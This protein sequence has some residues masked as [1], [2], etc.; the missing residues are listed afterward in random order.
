MRSIVKR[1]CYWEKGVYK[2]FDSS[3][4]GAGGDSND[5]HCN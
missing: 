4:I 1:V 2:D 5:H 3:V